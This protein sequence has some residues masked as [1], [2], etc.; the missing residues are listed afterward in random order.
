[1]SHFCATCHA[2]IADGVRV[3]PSCGA[4]Q[5]ARPSLAFGPGLTIERGYG[6]IVVDA[7]IGEGGMGLVWRGWL[8]YPPSAQGVTTAPVPI[9]IKVLKPQAAVREEVRRFF[10]TEAEALQ[11]ISHPNIV[12][13]HELFEWPPPPPGSAPGPGLESTQPMSLA[14]AME[15]VDGDTLEDVIARHIA[16]SVLRGPGGSL[17][18]MAFRRAWYYFQQLLGAL[19]ATH[20]LGIVHRDVKP[21]NVLIRRDGIVKLTDFGIARVDRPG[22]DDPRDKDLAPGTGAYMSPEQVLSHP[23]DG[24]SD[25]YSAAVVLY[26]MLT[27]RT[28]IVT[29]NKSEFVVRQEQVNVMPPPIRTFVAQAPPVLDALFARALAK[30]PAYRFNDA[31][32]MGSAFRE[33]LG[34]PETD[35]WRAQAE[36]AK[37]A[38][39]PTAPGEAAEQAQQQKLGTLREFLVKRY[40][41]MSMTAA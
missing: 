13:F 16:R 23:L 26:E 28:P 38:V 36:I 37:V 11:R 33:A 12:R 8:F 3:C 15:Y 1:V 6:R 35:E 14:L 39:A 17:P 25:L 10:L 24:R 30:D 5:P 40:K 9:A 41:T 7:R 4:L 34:I 19:A 22:G 29:Q 27:G 2:A 32:Q 31:I 20:A 21:S 18:G